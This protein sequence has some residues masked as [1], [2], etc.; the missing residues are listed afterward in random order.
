MGNL[1]III[2]CLTIIAN[3]RKASIMKIGKWCSNENKKGKQ[4][5]NPDLI[6]EY[7]C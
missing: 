1:P 3:F 5:R 6:Y 4:G 2:N 7:G